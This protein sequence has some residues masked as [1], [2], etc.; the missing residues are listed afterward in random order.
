MSKMQF[1]RQ[2]LATLIVLILGATNSGFAQV[3]LTGT[4]Y[5]QNFNSIGTALPTGWSVLTGATA[6]GLG[7]AATY[8]TTQLQWSNTTG[9]F[10]NTASATGLTGN[11]NQAT[12]NGIADRSLSIRQTGTFGDPGASFTFEAANTQGLSG[13]TLS[14]DLDML[15]VQTRSTT[16][17]IQ[18]ALGATPTTFTT[19]ETYT[20]P[21][22]FGVTTKSGLTLGTDVNNQS[23]PLWIRIVALSAATGSGSRDRLGIDN[24][25]LSYSAAG[26]G[27]TL[28]WTGNG[29]TFGGSGI[30]D[31]STS[32]TWSSSNSSVTPIVWDPTKAAV[33]GGTTSGTV[34]VNGSVNASAGMNFS[35]DGYVVNPGPSG[36]IVLT[37]ADA[38]TNSIGADIAVSSTINVPL[39]GTAGMTKVGAGTIILTANNTY[40]G[41]TTITAGTLQ[42]GSGGTTGSI[43]G[44]VTNNGTFKISRSDDIVYSNSITG[45][46]SF[47]QAGPGIVTLT[48]SVAATVGTTIAG[49]T[50]QLG[51]G[52]NP[53]SLMGGV[54]INSGERWRSFNPAI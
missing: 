31:A 48:D 34:T 49:G 4:S 35:T 47:V 21:G 46:G 14:L 5:T 15:D 39:D 10:G 54:T 36:K 26:G 8:S 33:F 22:V 38:A 50:L 23:D 51:D 30:W 32:A 11:E 44:D 6:T 18:Y 9:A 27:N 24:F 53:G 20:D 7:T 19:I 43:V 52:T 16:W 2:S 12:Q 41:G 1:R 40:T 45:N 37:G 25:V 13:F 17:S 3:T 42:V 28:F 29:T